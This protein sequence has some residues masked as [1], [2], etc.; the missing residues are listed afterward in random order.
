MV[1]RFQKHKVLTSHMVPWSYDSRA[2]LKDLENSFQEVN[3][4]FQLVHKCLLQYVQ[5]EQQLNLTREQLIKQ[6]TNF[7]PTLIASEAKLLKLMN[8]MANRMQN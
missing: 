4:N 5:Q 8:S 7:V 1:F 2:Q 3:E 6:R